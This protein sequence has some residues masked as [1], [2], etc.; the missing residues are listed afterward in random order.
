MG[1]RLTGIGERFLDYRLN[2]KLHDL[3]HAN[4]SKIEQLRSDL[5]HLQDRGRR[6]NELEFEALT[7]VWKAFVDAWLKTQQAIVEYME[8]PDLNNLSDNDLATF[9]DSTELS[10]PQRRQVVASATTQKNET[11]SK[12]MRLRTNNSAAAAIYEGRQTLRVNGVF[13]SGETA[14]RFKQA[15]DKLA[16][17]QVERYMEFRH[18]RSAGY[19]KSLEVLD[20]A[21]TGMIADLESLTRANI[22]RG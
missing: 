8:F 7:S 16:A 17:A 12:I 10:E 18:G 15:F 1:V 6:A 21:G 2:Q 14:K 13:I 4:A 20:T 9:L 19:D 22:R 5:A 3:E 11:Y